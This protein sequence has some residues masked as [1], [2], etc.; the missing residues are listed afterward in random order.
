MILKCGIVGSGFA[1]SFHYK[2]IK[3]VSG[4][5]VE[6]VGVYSRTASHS[7]T[8]A[9]ERNLP[10]FGS[11]EDLIGASDVIHICTPPAT[12][13]PFCVSALESDRSVIVEKPFTG[14]FGD[15]DGRSLSKEKALD[16]AMESV[17]R[18]LKAE[19]ASRGNVYYAENWVYAPAVQKEREII[20][21]S[22]AQVLWMHGEESHSGSHSP[23][24]GYRSR[25]GGG[26]MMGKGCH[27]L[28]AA[29][30]LK[31]VEGLA[32][33]GRPIRPRTVSGRTHEITRQ[34]GYIDKGHLRADY[35]DVEDYSFMHV[36]FEDGMLADIYANE[37]VLGGVHNWLEVCANNHR[38]ICRINPNN[39]M[40][41]YSPKEEYLRDVYVVEK[42]GTKQGWSCP[43]PDED[44]FTG[45]YQEMEAFYRNMA[46]LGDVA[47]NSQLAADTIAVIYSAYL[48]AEKGGQEVIIPRFQP[49]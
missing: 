1:A 6:I 11:L 41:T 24:Y 3:R 46:G 22:G 34:A 21:K 13:E 33:G 4:A 32:S 2:A 45:Y 29:L 18:I 12:H 39:A 9:A 15:E 7:R 42:I 23:D 26:S 36:V 38:T 25:A 47:S 19:A 20:E 49:S 30:Y 48:S 14:C 8:F 31:R 28:T 5:P 16:G 35:H 44:W 37:L 10:A 40:E 17:N 27:P 43:S